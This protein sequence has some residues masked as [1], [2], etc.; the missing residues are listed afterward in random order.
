MAN[1]AGGLNVG[2]PAGASKPTSVP[3]KKSSAA[4]K[5]K[6]KA[7]P[8][9]KQE[10]VWA[11]ALDEID[12][13]TGGL[14]SAYFKT[15]S[16][17][18]AAIERGVST[19]S[20]IEGAKALVTAPAAGVTSIANLLTDVVPDLPTGGIRF[21]T[22][23]PRGAEEYASL[24][25]LK[26]GRVPGEKF[27]DLSTGAQDVRI[28]EKKAAEVTKRL[29]SKERNKDRASGV[30]TQAQAAYE[31]KS[32]SDIAF[33]SEQAGLGPLARWQRKA[34]WEQAKANGHDIADP[35]KYTD[36]ELLRRAYSYS[37]PAGEIARGL[38]RGVGEFS[39]LPAAVPAIGGAILSGDTEE[40]KGLASGA[41]SP[42]RYYLE[43]IGRRGVG[44]ATS[45][46]VQER[47]LDALLL[48]VGSART[49]GRGAGVAA[50]TAG[51]TGESAIQVRIPK[52]PKGSV[53]ERLGQ[54]AAVDRPIE[55]PGGLVEVAGQETAAALPIAYS[56]KN[57]FGTLLNQGKARLLTAGMKTGRSE[58]VAA[59]SRRVAGERAKRAVRRAQDLRDDASVRATMELRDAAKG[60]DFQ[61]L[62]RLV[63]ELTMARIKPDEA[64]GGEY[65]VGSRAE[66]WRGRAA[67]AEKPSDKALFEQQ[68]KEW[69]QLASI[70]LEQATIDAARAASRHVGGDNDMIVSMIL[71]QLDA[72]ENPAG[73]TRVPARAGNIVVGDRIDIGP[74]DQVIPGFVRGVERTPDGVRITVENTL[75][76]SDIS[77]SVYEPFAQVQ[78]VKSS[79]AVAKYMRQLIEFEDSFKRAASEE[80]GLRRLERQLS[81]SPFNTAGRRFNLL[82]GRKATAFDELDRIQAQLDEAML[83][84]NRLRTKSLTRSY[85]KQVGKIIKMLR[86]Q[87]LL[88]A[89]TDRPDYA[90][91]LREV[92]TKIIESRGRA[93][94]KLE[95]I[96]QGLIARRAEQLRTPA[97]RDIRQPEAQA[98]AESA[99]RLEERASRLDE[100]VARAEQLRAEAPSAAKAGA[101]RRELAR[102][103]QEIKDL[104][105]Q[106]AAASRV[107]AGLEAEVSALKARLEYLVDSRVLRSSRRTADAFNKKYAPMRAEAARELARIRRKVIRDGRF[108]PE[109][110][111]ALAAVEKKIASAEK[112]LSS[113]VAFKVRPGGVKQTPD[114]FGT[115]GVSARIGESP[116]SV[117]GEAVAQRGERM[118]ELGQRVA[119]REAVP[120]SV[121]V[122]SAR[123]QAK[124]M[125]VEANKKRRRAAVIIERGRPVADMSGLRVAVDEARGLGAMRITLKDGRYFD[126]SMD[127][128]AGEMK[129]EWI[130]RAEMSGEDPV[131]WLGTRRAV[132]GGAPDLRTY[133]EGRLD[134]S[135]SAQIRASRLKTLRGQI[136]ESGAESTRQLW[137]K[138]LTDT[139]EIRGALAWQREMQRFILGVSVRVKALTESEAESI[140]QAMNEA[141]FTKAD[142]T[143][144]YDLDPS[145][146]IK[147]GDKIVFDAREYVA[148]NPFQ[149]NVRIPQQVKMGAAEGKTDIPN[150]SDL[151]MREA[152]PADVIK[153]GG[154]YL[155]VPR[156]VY[157]AIQ[158]ELRDLSY[159]PS[160]TER[161]LSNITKEWRNFTLNIFPR[162]GVA[163]L[164]GSSI[165]AAL[166]GAGPK[167]FYLAYR[168]I[169]YGDVPAPTQLRQRF[170]MSLTTNE[171]F[172]WLRTNYPLFEHP[173]GALSWWMNTMRR[174][175]GISEDFG[176]LA[177]W[178]SKAYPEA[179][180][181]SSEGRLG[182]WKQMKVVTQGAEE[183]LE[184]FAKNDP[185]F[186]AKSQRFVDDAFQWVGDLHSGGKWNYRLRIAFPFNQWYRHIIRLMLITMPFKYPGRTLFLTRLNEMGQEYQREHGVTAPWFAD[187]IPIL[188]DEKIIDGQRQEYPLLYRVSTVSPFTTLSS[189]VSGDQFD[190]ADY[191][192]G[193]LAPIW[194][195]A[196]LIVFSGISGEAKQFGGGNIIRS[197]E[198][199]YGNTIKIGSQDG[200]KYMANLLFQSLPMSSTAASSAGQ[201][202][203]GNVLWSSSERLLR[204]S[205]GVMPLSVKPPTAPGKDIAQLATDFSYEN[206]VALAGRLMFGGGLS[207]GIGRGPVENAQFRAMIRNQQASFTREQSNILR[208]LEA[209][210]K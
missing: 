57:L 55:V 44:P 1:G 195:N 51:G 134:I 102:I 69:E 146:T 75:N 174:F 41:I 80:L 182:A 85:Q 202:A 19:G 46:F 156:F 185:E 56:G 124:R 169:R 108:T 206:F 92:R 13:K 159:E 42:Y 157:E 48:G 31:G 77:T 90:A 177:V 64:G 24:G 209:Q 190:W 58:K 122:Q 186:A 38:V 40:M 140:K 12:S 147:E 164:A 144:L 79:V 184:A 141:G 43:D 29:L 72:A 197:A 183:M 136:Y 83:A 25:P 145:V 100:L 176:R 135:P 191:G 111:A 120:T 110:I 153:A 4:E 200:F 71:E 193:A 152:A 60:L 47:P 65:T 68:A 128:I 89:K 7:K 106:E 194:K 9:P 142:G 50:R 66:Y 23:L 130:A 208:T 149:K 118:N 192:A 126:A 180:R 119:E 158:R 127:Q 173:L 101:A 125:R 10:P 54:Y 34:L 2:K 99:A 82:E 93:V 36:A 76:P 109:D 133:G 37:T 6:A 103:E 94:G 131:L 104:Q 86:E 132:F 168:H 204:G 88:A 203:E 3:A 15:I 105:A 178:Y 113:Y 163:N 49:L 172:E 143:P 187:V 112:K 138:L 179:A 166:A 137:E 188:Q 96:D 28:D 52:P 26:F 150:L 123:A 175:N 199:V 18:G 165:L 27:R 155:L 161:A 53:R 35:Q 201:A 11:S 171:D 16:P 117:L 167:S 61:Q 67:D 14:A 98:L 139:G 91:Q 45:S 205:E 198:N 70:P 84:G 95:P 21:G 20:P 121:D 196:A 59:V 210:N 97:I 30:A 74:A 181:L 81:V 154:E 189:A 17:L 8:K 32:A 73:L 170:G 22:A 115:V 33:M 148:I 62:R 5:V 107:P 129:E 78:K 114:G 160:G 63:V 87:E 162:T 116:K 151:F 39:S 207:Y